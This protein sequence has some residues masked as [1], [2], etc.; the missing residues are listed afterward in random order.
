GS[1]ASASRWGELPGTAG[2]ERFA[3]WS[4]RFGGEYAGGAVSWYVASLRDGD[5]H[6]AREVNGSA[7][8]VSETDGGEV[9]ASCGQTFRPLIRLAGHPPDPL[10]VCRACWE[11]CR[12]PMA[13]TPYTNG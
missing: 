10:Q 4:P 12:T 2:R 11:I 6:L 7:A 1:W 3:G 8:D 5:T 9:R 13:D